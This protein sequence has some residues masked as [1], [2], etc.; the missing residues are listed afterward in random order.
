MSTPAAIP[1][2]PWWKH[3]TLQPD[4]SR[5][6]R[7]TV[8]F[9]VPL[10]LAVTGWL[11]TDV[12]FTAITAQ[13]LAMVDVRGDYRLRLGLLLGMT[14]VFVGVVTL[15]TAV[16]HSLGDAV[17]ATVLVSVGASA[18]RHLSSDYGPSLAITSTF[19]FLFALASPPGTTH[20]AGPVLSTVIGAVWGIAVQVC[21]WPLR[22][23]HPLRRVVSDSWL[24]VAELFDALGNNS[25]ESA[26]QHHERIAD[27][28]AALRTA[29]DAATAALTSPRRSAFRTELDALNFAAARLALRVSALNTALDSLDRLAGFAGLAPALEPLLTNLSNL[30]RSVAVTVVSRQ[31]EHFVTFEVRLRRATAL[32]EVVRA[33]IALRVTPAGAAEQLVEILGQIEAHLPAIHDALRATVARADERAAFS[34]ELLDLRA[35]ALR[36]LASSLNLTWKVDPALVRFTYRST[37]LTA[38]GVIAWKTLHLAHGYWLPFTAIVV[39]QPDYGSTRR[40]AAQRVLG[41]LAGSIAASLL[42]MLRLGPVVLMIACAATIFIFGYWIKRNYGVAVIF[43]TLFVV[44]LTEATGPVTI[45]LAEQR[46]GNTLAGGLLALLA[47]HLFWP[48]WERER[49]PP[50]IVQALRE[51]RAY[52][53]VLANRVVTGGTFDAAAVSVKRK[54]ER[55]NS[56]VFSS[57]TRL[58]GDPKNQR[59]GLEHAATVANG[60]QRI[61]R[62]LNVLAVHLT[63]DAPW[64][65]PGID[66]FVEIAD[67][68]FD[69]LIAAV[70]GGMPAPSVVEPVLRALESEPLPLPPDDAGRAR[71]GFRQLTHTATELSALLVAVQNAAPARGEEMLKR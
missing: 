25:A 18:W 64:S 7:S 19:V 36:P 14:A 12:A 52:L 13:N 37:I 55:A 9:M 38:F 70:E 53:R 28:E 44:L 51:N 34:L 26:A 65:D 59:E 3:P 17:A 31:P 57:L 54:V 20:G 66:A 2:E 16:E 10:L 5:A 15:G 62:A 69:L 41:T 43:I 24:A 22:P 11:P 23:Q 40:R 63:P 35:L 4:V 8:A 50:I 27:K 39:L 46:L 42:L 33:R 67:R 30:S 49:L 58:H 47:A 56:A 68:A 29:L 6:L 1:S 32:L 71:W 48:V 45:A 60:N 61:T 21:A